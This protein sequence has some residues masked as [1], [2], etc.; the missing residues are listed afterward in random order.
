MKLLTV[1]ET[2]ASPNS[3]TAGTA[4]CQGKALV[5]DRQRANR[6]FLGAIAGRQR[7][8]TFLV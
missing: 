7:A 5:Y 8:L 3:C 2:N 6:A 1:S 4:R